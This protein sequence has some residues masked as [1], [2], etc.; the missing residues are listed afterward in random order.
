MGG[1]HPT[2]GFKPCQRIGVVTLGPTWLNA[3]V[4]Y[5][6]YS[7]VKKEMSGIAVDA[8]GGYSALP[9]ELRPSGWRVDTTIPEGRWIMAQLGY[10]PVPLAPLW[11]L[12][13]S[14]GV[15]LMSLLLSGYL[16]LRLRGQRQVAPTTEQPPEQV[17]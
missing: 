5:P 12:N 4:Q 15:S 9:A 14:L 1:E 13:L 6:P 11:L 3:S 10:T 2:Y 16:L 7:R 8:G 17:G